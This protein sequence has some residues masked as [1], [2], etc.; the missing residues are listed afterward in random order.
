MSRRRSTDDC[1]TF[2]GKP[3]AL[4]VRVTVLCHNTAMSPKGSVSKLL[5]EFAKGVR[6]SGQAAQFNEET[7]TAPTRDLILAM[8]EQVGAGDL[9]VVDK[10]PVV[11]AG[12]SVGVP[13]LSVY[14]KGLLRLV[15]ELKAPDKGADPTAFK[16]THDKNQW[17]RYRRWRCVQISKT[18]TRRLHRTRKRFFGF[19]VT[20]LLGTLRSS[21]QPSNLRVRQRGAAAHCVPMSVPFPR[22]PWR[23]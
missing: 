1:Q 8:G 20:R 17:Q 12:V 22:R 5:S 3:S 21:P 11:L 14:S 9:V 23:A 6:E 19:L 7:L 4:T 13:D 10:S 2:L 15:V 18:Q 16:V